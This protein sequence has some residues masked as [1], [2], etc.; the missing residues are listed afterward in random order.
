[1]KT[2]VKLICASFAALLMA[3]SCTQEEEVQITFSSDPE[4]LVDVPCKDP[5]EQVAERFVRT[6]EQRHPGQR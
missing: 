4:A 1:M 5:S 3:S 6:D 2:Y